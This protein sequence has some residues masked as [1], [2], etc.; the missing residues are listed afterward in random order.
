MSAINKLIINDYNNK[1]ARAKKV[2]KNWGKRKRKIYHH[3][4]LSKKKYFRKSSSQV[5]RENATV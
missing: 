4:R 1:F 5:L 2:R 3:V